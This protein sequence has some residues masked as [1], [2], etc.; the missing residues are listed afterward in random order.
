[1]ML[2]KRNKPNYLHE[3]EESKIDEC[4]RETE[5]DVQGC[6]IIH[7]YYNLQK[8]NKMIVDL[9]ESSIRKNQFKERQ[10]VLNNKLNN[11]ILRFIDNEGNYNGLY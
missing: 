10:K 1:M 3:N 6:R 5:K 8:T 11:E 9:P 4:F 2:D 7:A